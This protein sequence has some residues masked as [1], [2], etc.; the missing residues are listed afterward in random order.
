MIENVRHGRRTDAARR[1]GGADDHLRQCLKTPVT[2]QAASYRGRPVLATALAVFVQ[3]VLQR[4]P[5]TLDSHALFASA[6][7]FTMAAVVGLT[8]AGA[9][10]ATRTGTLRRPV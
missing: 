2:V 3:F 5:L 6:A 1:I 4:V 7:W 9:W 10:L 8:A